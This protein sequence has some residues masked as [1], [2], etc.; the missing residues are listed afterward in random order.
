MIGLPSWSGIPSWSGPRRAGGATPSP[1]DP[2]ASL[3][4]VGVGNVFLDLKPADAVLDGSGNVVS[5]PNAAGGAAATASATGITIAGGRFSPPGGNNGPC[6]MLPEDF[7]LFAARLFMLLHFPGPHPTTGN[8]TYIG[9][10]SDVVS[11][12]ST[13]SVRYEHQNRRTQLRRWAGP[14]SVSA[15]T[16]QGSAFP[17]VETL[18]EIDCSGGRG[19]VDL[20]TVE[21]SNSALNAAHPDFRINA[22]FRGA[23]NSASFGGSCG[24]II[25][26]RADGVTDLT[27]QIAAIRGAYGR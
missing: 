5:V 14:G 1:T 27:A 21:V 19:R 17:E 3:Y 11:D 16:L 13:T 25:G 23:D 2:V 9:R 12:G 4:G 7:D 18:F 26:L 15:S 8:F 20:D 22:I 10:L 6:L 24:R